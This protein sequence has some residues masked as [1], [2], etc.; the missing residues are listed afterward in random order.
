M[1]ILTETHDAVEP[2]SG[3]RYTSTSSEPRPGTSAGERWV[4]IWSRL[5]VLRQHATSD[6]IRTAAATVALRDGTSLLVYGTVLPWCGDPRHGHPSK[7]SVAY[8]A[9]LAEPAN[10]WHRLQQEFPEA[11][12]CVAG[13]FNQDLSDRHYYWSREARE[14]LRRTLCETELEAVTGGELDPVARAS[15]GQKRCIDHVCLSQSLAGNAYSEA[16][17]PRIGER[18]VSDHYGIAITL[19]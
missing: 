5:P 1:W 19:S 4:T 17:S 14:A 18:N 2:T 3:G 7:G 8:K 16:W 10:D 9:A 12:L 6:P 13:D 15:D 11:A